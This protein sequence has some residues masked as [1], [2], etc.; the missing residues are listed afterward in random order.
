MALMLDPNSEDYLILDPESEDQLILDER[1]DPLLDEEGNPLLAEGLPVLVLQS[2]FVPGG[3][4]TEGQVIQAVAQPWFELVQFL[5]RNPHALHEVSPRVW[6]EIIATAYKRAQFD[7]V[8]LTPRSGDLGRDVIAIK[9]GIGTVR[10]ID[11]IKA[12]KPGHLV[13]ADD[14][15]AL[16]GV[17]HGDRASKGFLTTTSDF[18]P[19][20]RDDAL[21]VRFIPAQLEL[22]NGK[23]LMAQLKELLTPL[24]GHAVTRPALARAVH[25][26]GLACSRS[27]IVRPNPSS[28][29]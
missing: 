4:T 13:T 24:T 8:I 12:Y 14:V 29:S 23:Q 26:D 28:Q 17:L 20:L 1:G 16:V 19:R 6:E 11:Q 15:R 2:I 9:R 22:I 27:R 5:L 7:E 18:A 3:V 10:V 25:H 21:M